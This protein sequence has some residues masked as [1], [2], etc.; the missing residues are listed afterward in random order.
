MSRPRTYSAAFAAKRALLPGPEDDTDDEGGIDA[1]RCEYCDGT[2]DVHQA[3]GVWFGA[4]TC[5]AG[6]ALLT[7]NV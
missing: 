5:E 4:C 2:G 6:K 3:D 7:P 1:E